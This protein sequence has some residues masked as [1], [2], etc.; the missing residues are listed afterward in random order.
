MKTKTTL[1]ALLL[2]AVMVTPS[3]GRDGGFMVGAYE[4]KKYKMGDAG[5]VFSWLDL[6][7]FYG[8]VEAVWHTNTVVAPKAIKKPGWVFDVVSEYIHQHPEYEHESA[9]QLIKRAF[10]EAWPEE[11]KHVLVSK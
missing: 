7:I 10:K 11:N 4:H 8:K 9:I 6:G 3:Y 1:A 5:D 2:A